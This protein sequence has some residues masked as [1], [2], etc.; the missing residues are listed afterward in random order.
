[1]VPEDKISNYYQIVLGKFFQRPVPTDSVTEGAVLIS[2]Q[3]PTGFIILFTGV[4]VI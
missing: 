1:L 2:V 3:S 4:M